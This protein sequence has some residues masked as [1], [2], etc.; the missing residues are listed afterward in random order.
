MAEMNRR[1]FVTLAGTLAC[2]CLCASERLLAEAPAKPVVVG[3]LKDFAQDGVVDKWA[4]SHRF[5]L[6]RHQGQL[7]ALA[8]RCTH[9]ATAA[10]VA[11]PNR[12]ACPR[13]GSLFTL[14]GIVSKGP[15]QRSLARFGIRLD[16]QQQI[17]VDPSQRYEEGQ[18]N[19]PGSHLKVG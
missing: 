18:W 6:V 14:A 12:L 15:A 13:H 1:E 3:T 16:Q 7:Y 4:Q 5:F 2:G 8:S 11:E 9:K 10:L 17:I 19:Q